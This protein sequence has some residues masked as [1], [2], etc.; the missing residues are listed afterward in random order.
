MEIRALRRLIHTEKKDE[1]TYYFH[2]KFKFL[3]TVWNTNVQ[4][5]EVEPYFDQISKYDFSDHVFAMKLILDETEFYLEK[6][7][8]IIQNLLASDLQLSPNTK[9]SDTISSLSDPLKFFDHLISFHGLNEQKKAF[10]KDATDE[11]GYYTPYIK[12]IA[13]DGESFTFYD[14]EEETSTYNVITKIFYD[15]L[16]TLVINEFNLSANFIDQLL[17]NQGT[18]ES[19]I[20][21]LVNRCYN[22]LI[23]LHKRVLSDDKYLKYPVIINALN[24]FESRISGKYSTFIDPKLIESFNPKRC[25]ETPAERLIW[26]DGSTAFIALFLNL[27]KNRSISLASSSDLDPIYKKIESFFYVKKKASIKE[28]NEDPTIPYVKGTAVIQYFRKAHSDPK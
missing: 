26:N 21:T 22:Q 17:I 5:E 15:D 20:K 2:S 3:S 9:V 18:N 16:K 24:A 8:S 27:I 4:E 23:Y 14:V 25:I 11:D 6:L 7:I 13:P 19:E 28:E 1:V 12:E 10:L